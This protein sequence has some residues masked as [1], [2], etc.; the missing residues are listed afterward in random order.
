MT[1]KLE[2]PV[3][4]FHSSRRRDVR[5]RVDFV[6]GLLSQWYPV[7]DLLGP[8]EGARDAGP[9]DVSK[10]TRSFLQ[11]DLTVLP[12]GADADAAQR[13][14]DLP[15]VAGD[16]P[17]GY[18]REVNASWVRTKPRTDS[19]RA[20]PEEAERYL[21]Y[22]GLGRFGLPLDARS[23][24]NGMVVLLNRGDA[25]LGPAIVMEI[26]GERGRM[27]I[28]DPVPAGGG[29]KAVLRDG[30]WWGPRSDIER[31]L[32]ALLA[33][34]LREEGLDA[35]EARA[36]VRTWARSWFGTQ[37]LRVLWIVPRAVVDRVL[38]LSIDPAPDALVRVLV[39]RTELI[40]PDE[41]AADT[42]AVRDWSSADGDVRAAAR[43][44]LAA[45]ERFLEPHVRNVLAATDDTAVRANAV[46]IL[47]RIGAAEEAR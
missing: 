16:D 47:A 21:F 8:P 43:A 22:R 30:K 35:D 17:W 46:A 1:Q 20:G 13:P 37:G 12:Q 45:L 25:P 27:T 15:D 31:K 9:L 6:G 34:R 3:V 18:A 39:G 32:A 14:A 19:G 28:S 33:K 40:T 4:Y 26:R 10:V 41:A 7:S 42:K 5:V 29:V 36:M 44:H 11:W 2:T 24:G 23:Y 38:P